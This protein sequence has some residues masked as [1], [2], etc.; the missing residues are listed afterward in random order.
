[1]WPAGSQRFVLRHSRQVGIGLQPGCAVEGRIAPRTIS[2]Q[3]RSNFALATL[4]AGRKAGAARTAMVF[5]SAHREREAGAAP[6]DEK[7]M[8]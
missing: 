1:M 3:H 6:G 4:S 7:E 2:T 8:L 5:E